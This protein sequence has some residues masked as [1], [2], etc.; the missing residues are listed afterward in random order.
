VMTMFFGVVFAKA[1]GLELAGRAVVLPLVAT[2]LLWINLVT[3]GAPALALGL[4]P[5]DDAL[6]RRRPR[7]SSEPVI[8]AKM[9]RGIFFVG[10]VMAIGTLAVLDAALPGGRIEG[11]GTLRHAQT[12]AFT[13]LVLFQMFN[14]FNARS[15]D[16]SAFRGLFVNRWLWA[17]IALSVALHVIVVYMPVLQRAFSTESLSRRDWLVCVAV[18][19]SVLWIREIEKMMERR[20]RA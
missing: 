5:P 9:W 14:L 10:A 4:D 16:E 6:M 19:S 1:I 2:Q 8:T 3:D 11:A 7:P 12:Q 13:T 18:A 17:A 20:F 15:D